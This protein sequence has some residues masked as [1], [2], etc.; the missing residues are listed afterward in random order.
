M[1]SINTREFIIRA[2]EIL[3]TILATYFAVYPLHGKP[4]FII[5]VLIVPVLVLVLCELLHAKYVIVPKL[6]NYITTRDREEQT[7]QQLERLRLQMEKMAECLLSGEIAPRLVSL[8]IRMLGR[9]NAQVSAA[10]LDDVWNQLTWSLSK[11]YF[12]TNYINYEHMYGNTRSKAIIATQRAK[13]L[14]EGVTV[15]KV[16]IVKDEDEI[17]STE[18]KKTLALHRNEGIVDLFYIVKTDISNVLGE[19][20]TITDDNL[21]FGIFDGSVVLC[22]HFDKNRKIKGGKLFFGENEVRP[23][24]EFANLLKAVSKKCP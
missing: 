10:E 11:T 8:I 18:A 19:K 5:E 6:E 15:S 4:A 14:A 13:M 2:I 24:R 7:R 17:N 1:I 9:A 3:V 16:F 20:L 23:Y 22:W 21:D 12:A